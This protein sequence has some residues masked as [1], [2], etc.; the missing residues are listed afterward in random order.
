MLSTMALLL[1]VWT[2]LVYRRIYEAQVRFTFY[3]SL[4]NGLLQLDRALIDYPQLWGIYDADSF[5]QSTLADPLLRGRALALC[6]MYFN[7]FE[8]AFEGYCRRGLATYASEREYR[9]SWGKWLAEFLEHSTFA[10][11]IWIE[12]ARPKYPQSFATVVD[13]ILHT[14]GHLPRPLQPTTGPRAPHSI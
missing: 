14:Q 13:Q 5:N 4:E 6:Y 11:T 3:A 8:A 7:L 12:E 1:S 2:F 10:R 9:A